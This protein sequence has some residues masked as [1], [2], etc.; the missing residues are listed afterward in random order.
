MF[1]F[2]N[3]RKDGYEKNYSNDFDMFYHILTK[4]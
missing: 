1:I 3:E 4:L 2:I